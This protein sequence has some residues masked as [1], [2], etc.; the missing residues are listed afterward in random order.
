[1]AFHDTMRRAIVAA[2]FI[3]WGVTTQAQTNPAPVKV[4]IDLS[5]T[6]PAATIGITSKNAILM[7]PKTLGGRPAQ[8][9]SAR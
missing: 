4:G 2:A 9:H 8:I 6:G 3:A 1:M 7:W 5:S